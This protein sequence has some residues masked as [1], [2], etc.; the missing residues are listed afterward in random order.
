MGVSRLSV[1]RLSLQRRETR[2]VEWIERVILKRGNSIL[3]Y[4]TFHTFLALCT[5]CLCTAVLR[6]ST[7]CSLGRMAYSI[8]PHGRKPAEW[9]AGDAP[10]TG[11]GGT[12]SKH[13]SES[14]LRC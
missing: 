13:R 14:C 6:S 2:F 12:G 3:Y 5:D 8:A 7:D 11:G 4:G 9:S 10:P 1:G